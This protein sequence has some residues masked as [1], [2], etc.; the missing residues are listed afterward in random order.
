[1]KY[2][3][4][5][6]FVIVIGLICVAGPSTVAAQNQP[7]P[8]AKEKAE[9][10]EASDET[11]TKADRDSIRISPKWARRKALRAV[12]D[13]VVGWEVEK[14]EGRVQYEFKI[15]GKDGK[16]YEVEIDALT[17]KVVEAEIS[18]Q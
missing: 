2:P 3:I 17:G 7:A 9:S 4:F 11:V 12:P 8:A 6:L 5:A 10:E 14:E 16:R 1:M 13:K 15:A 18:E